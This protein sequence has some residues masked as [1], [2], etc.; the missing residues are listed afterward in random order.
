MKK[1][2]K[3]WV[4]ENGFP[5]FIYGDRIYLT[6]H[7]D[8]DTHINEVLSMVKRNLDN[9]N[10]YL[11]MGHFTNREKAIKYINQRNELTSKGMFVE[12]AIYLL[13]GQYIGSISFTNIDYK[14]LGVIYYLDKRYSCF[15]YMSEALKIAEKQMQ[16]IGFEKIVLE[17]NK[18][19]SA[20]L[21][22]A[23]A[24]NYQYQKDEEYITMLNYVKQLGR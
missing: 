6:L 4:P 5:D 14:T 1:F 22:L 3:M 21:N 20:S 12:Y 11:E 15:G 18:E 2:N 19:N 13:T 9:F 10:V 16:K 23:K 8:S 7:D 17:I 24:N